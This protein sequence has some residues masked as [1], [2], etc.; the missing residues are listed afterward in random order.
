[1]GNLPR[2]SRRCSGRNSSRWRGLSTMCAS[3]A[4]SATGALL[5]LSTWRDEKSVV[6]WRTQPSIT[7]CRRQGRAGIFSDY[8][9][10]VGEFAADSRLPEGQ[11]LR[12]A[13]IGHDRVRRRHDR[14]HDHRGAPGVVVWV[15]VYE[16]ADESRVAWQRYEILRPPARVS[17]WH[18]GGM[19]Q[20]SRHGT[21]RRPALRRSASLRWMP[22]R[23]VRV[24]R[25]Y[26]MFDRREAPQYYPPVTPIPSARL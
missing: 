15:D 5:S 4:G 13:A 19:R 3:P 16:S 10:R 9:L 11:A 14:T 24:M 7:K 21:P 2:H 26:G 20:R 17:G 22:L 12:R 18:R 23:A 8:H 1:M 25:D 6:R